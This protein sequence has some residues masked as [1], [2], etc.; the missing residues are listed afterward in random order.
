M[1]EVALDRAWLEANLPHRGA[2]SV[3]ER[4]V[5]WDATSLEAVAS[6]H[7]APDHPLRRAGELPIA[8]GI[9]FGAQAAAAHGALVSGRPSSSGFLASVRAV[10]F[11]ARRL[12]LVESL[13]DVHA[14]QLGAGDAGVIYRF[15]V[16]AGGAPLIDRRVAVAFVP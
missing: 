9:E 3:L 6:G 4:I 8:A 12:D 7:R 15:S 13:L 16:S 5:R 2:M 10:R 14:E 11:H 1:T